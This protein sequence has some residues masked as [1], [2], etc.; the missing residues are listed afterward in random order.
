MEYVKLNNGIEMP[1]LGIGTFMSTHPA[2]CKQAVLDAIHAGYRLIDTAQGYSNEAYIGNAI[3]QSPVERG[4]LFITTKVWFRNHDNCRASVIESMKKLQTDY[5][6]LVL[7]HW[8]FG[9]T[10]AAWRDLEQLYAEGRIRAIGV[11]NYNADRLVDLV[12]HSQVTPQVNQV[13]TNLTSQQA[14]LKQWMRKYGVQHEGYA[15]FGQGRMDEMYDHEA[16]K[17][18][19]GRYGKTTRQVVLRYQVQSGVV[20]IPKTT[21]I[22]RMK[23]NLDIFDFSLL[24]NEMEILRSFDRATPMIGNPQ[25]PSLVESSQN[26][27]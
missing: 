27:G 19:A 18:I 1:A 15:P 26:W 24:D 12:L 13:E 4:Q 10:Y 20:V 2:V 6:D 16:L 25:N 3:A 11:S 8:P 17:N 14:E 9:D 23:E 5:L 22:E 7:I 21:H